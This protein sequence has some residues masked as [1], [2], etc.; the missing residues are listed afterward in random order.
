MW[1][2]KKK[3]KNSGS[4][5]Y[6]FSSATSSYVISSKSLIL[7]ELKGPPN[8]NIMCMYYF[9]DKMKNLSSFY[10]NTEW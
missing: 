7:S 5:V 6:T 10:F 2:S 9:F 4:P 8:V 1:Y 3:T